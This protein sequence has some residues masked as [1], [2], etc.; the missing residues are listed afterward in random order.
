MNQLN[1]YAERFRTV[2]FHREDGILQMTLHS[3]GGPL[4]WGKVPHAELADAFCASR[5]I[6]TT[7]SSS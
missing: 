1:T 4:V 7:S 3:D 6:V 5:R 2:C